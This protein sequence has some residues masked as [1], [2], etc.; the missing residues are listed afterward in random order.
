MFAEGS[1]GLVSGRK[2]RKGERLLSLRAVKRPLSL[3]KVLS[4][5]SGFSVLE[6]LWKK[7]LKNASYWSRKSWAIGK[8]VGKSN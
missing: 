3:G 5:P 6:K 7:Q 8:E 4:S 1:E 2:G